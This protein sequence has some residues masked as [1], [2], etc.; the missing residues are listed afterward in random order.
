MQ[1]SRRSRRPAVS[2]ESRRGKPRRVALQ[3]VADGIGKLVAVKDVSRRL[4][5]DREV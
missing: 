2:E 5:L 4:R 3:R 1:A